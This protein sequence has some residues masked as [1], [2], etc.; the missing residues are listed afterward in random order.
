MSYKC[1]L[2]LVGL[3]AATA[4]AVDILT[5]PVGNADDTVG[6]PSPMTSDYIE[7]HARSAIRA[8]A[9]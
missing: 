7:V 1:S 8:D 9:S 2:V 4:S 5:V 6:Y 3:L